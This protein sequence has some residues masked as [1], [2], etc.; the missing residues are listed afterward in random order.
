MDSKRRPHRSHARRSSTGRR[1]CHYCVSALAAAFF[2]IGIPHD[3]LIIDEEQIKAGKYMV[4]AHAAQGEL[5][6]A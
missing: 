4:I 1:D 6:K 2:S 5:N 3:S